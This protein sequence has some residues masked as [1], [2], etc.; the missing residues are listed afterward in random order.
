MST[1]K[2]RGPD[3][4]PD[5]GRYDVYFIDRNDNQAAG[6]FLGHDQGSDEIGENA[7]SGKNEQNPDKRGTDAEIFGDAAAH[8]CDH[9][10]RFAPA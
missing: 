6:L 8:A 10:I 7:D 9:F 1:A 5:R 4:W 2:S 3:G